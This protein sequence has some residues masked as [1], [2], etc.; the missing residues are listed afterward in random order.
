M[1]IKIYFISYFSVFIP[2]FNSLWVLY[3]GFF[4]VGII[5][6]SFRELTLQ[7]SY[8]IFCAQYSKKKEREFVGDI[9]L[10]NVVGVLDA[11]ALFWSVNLVNIKSDKKGVSRIFCRHL[12]NTGYSSSCYRPWPWWFEES[13]HSPSPYSN[14]QKSLNIWFFLFFF[15]SEGTK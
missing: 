14:F 8:L 5:S 15:S 2:W 13:S 6:W 11:V 7:E 10:N 3:V 1:L 12:N 4:F 9:L